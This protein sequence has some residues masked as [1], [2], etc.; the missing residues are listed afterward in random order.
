MTLTGDIRSMLAGTVPLADRSPDTAQDDINAAFAV[1]AETSQSKVFVGSFAGK[2]GWE[3][4]E[5][6][7]ELVH[8][9]EGKTELT[10]LLGKLKEVSSLRAGMVAII[11]VGLW[12]RFDAPDGVTILTA[13]PMPTEHYPGDLPGT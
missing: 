7:D 5:N 8:I 10:V 4:H 13:T 2:S 12:H 9:L 11:P 6:G 3:R 1:V